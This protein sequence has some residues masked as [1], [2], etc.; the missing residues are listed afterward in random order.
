MTTRID[1]LLLDV[2]HSFRI[3]QELSRL[4]YTVDTVSSVAALGNDTPSDE[5]AAQDGCVVAV[6]DKAHQHQLVEVVR[7]LT[8][9]T[10]QPIVLV[11]PPLGENDR[12]SVLRNGAAAIMENTLP[13]REIA[14]RV[15]R[16]L[17][18]R[19][20]ENP[21]TPMCGSWE[22][23]EQLLIV[24]DDVHKAFLNGEYVRLTE[25][26]WRLLHYLAYRA[27][28]ICARE[29]I[30]HESMGYDEAAPYLRSL[31]AHI[32]NVRK[33]LGDGAWIETVRGFGYQFVGSRTEDTGC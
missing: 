13:I 20:V 3:K 33:K 29:S 10:D 7:H 8:I 28:A 21:R 12:L 4:G 32:K 24:D 22:L 25:T 27:P 1:L 19:R 5:S 15:D 9:R 30:I 31:D 23:G 6:V 18:F 16:L 14:V 26:E 2:D 17:A 11:T